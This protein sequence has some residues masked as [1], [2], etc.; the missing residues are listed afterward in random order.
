MGTG[1]LQLRTAADRRLSQAAYKAPRPL[2]LWITTSPNARRRL[3]SHFGARWKLEFVT[4][5]GGPRATTLTMN[6]TNSKGARLAGRCARVSPVL[7]FEF[8]VALVATESLSFS[9][10]GCVRPGIRTVPLWQW[11]GDRRPSPPRIR[12]DTAA[13]GS[14]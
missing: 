3:S 10:A 14:R 2:S 13:M 6:M 4:R 5:E 1:G 8:N 12:I 9:F 11:A 7:H